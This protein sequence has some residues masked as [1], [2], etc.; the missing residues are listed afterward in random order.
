MEPAFWSA[1]GFA[2]VADG[3]LV[4]VLSYQSE[5]LETA[6]KLVRVIRDY[7]P[8]P[9]PI[10]LVHPAGR[11][12]SPTVRLFIDAAVPELR[13]KFRVAANEAG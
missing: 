7:E 8:A 10:N 4:R 2:A 11:Y 12:L 3:G 5:P 1:R 6:G 9:N 13:R